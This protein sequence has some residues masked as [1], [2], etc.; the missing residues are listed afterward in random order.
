MAQ[1]PLDD[2]GNCQYGDCTMEGVTFVCPDGLEEYHENVLA[3]CMRHRDYHL[4]NG[5]HEAKMVTPEFAMEYIRQRGFNPVMRPDGS[6][7][8]QRER[9]N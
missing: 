3:V 9:F 1:L 2:D 5:W 4:S 8:V 6:I 7:Y